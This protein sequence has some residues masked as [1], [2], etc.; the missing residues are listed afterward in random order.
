M[1]WTYH[2]FQ[3]LSCTP[4][5]RIRA[6]EDGDKERGLGFEPV[7]HFVHS[8]FKDLI[9]GIVLLWSVHSDM[10]DMLHGESHFDDLIRDMGDRCGEMRWGH[11]DS[12][13]QQLRCVC[14]QRTATDSST[15]HIK[16]SFPSQG[17]QRYVGRALYR[18]RRQHRCWPRRCFTSNCSS[19]CL[20][21]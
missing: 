16:P 20:R 2:F 14:G 3:I 18:S 8:L 4:S 9:H 6:A 10:H 13:L 5:L 7:E 15:M 21:I 17:R 1:R 19:N 11:L 12:S